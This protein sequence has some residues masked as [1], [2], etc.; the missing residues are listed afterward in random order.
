MNVSV[1][2]Y[3]FCTYQNIHFKHTLKV[4]VTMFTTKHISDDTFKEWGKNNNK[5]NNNVFKSKFYIDLKLLKIWTFC[6]H[7]HDRSNNWQEMMKNS[8]S[9]PHQDYT[10]NVTFLCI[11]INVGYTNNNIRY[12]C[13]N[14]H[15]TKICL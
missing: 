2:M 10:P 14:V 1:K 11:I 6:R 12:Q 15:D 9:A 3:H 7:I 5:N 4:S 13:S 8:D